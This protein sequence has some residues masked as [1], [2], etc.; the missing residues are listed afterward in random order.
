MDGGDCTVANDG[1]FHYHS[2]Q[3]RQDHKEWLNIRIAL[4]IQES[5]GIR[6]SVCVFIPREI[7]KNASQGRSPINKN[8]EA[9]SFK[10]ESRPI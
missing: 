10:S 3:L 1:E 6:Q 8:I 7:A 4:S 9:V 5:I 2:T